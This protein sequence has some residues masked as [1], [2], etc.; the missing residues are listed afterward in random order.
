MSW[1]WSDRPA[2]A[3]VKHLIGGDK[4]AAVY[5]IGKYEVTVP[6]EER[7]VTYRVPSH[8]RGDP[9][10][11][12]PNMEIR[13]GEV[14]IPVSDFADEILSRVPA[15][16]LA[17]GLWENDEVRQAFLE[18]VPTRWDGSFSD[19]ERR[20]LLRDLKETVHSVALDKLANT[21]AKL[22]YD[23]SKRSFH[24]HEVNR[25]NDRLHEIEIELRGRLG[26]AAFSLPRVRHADNDGDFAI[27]G[28][29][30]NEARED[31]RR[32]VLARYPFDAPAL[33][34]TQGEEA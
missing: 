21:M 25:V 28:K 24:Y 8:Y 9:R 34:K 19:F 16:E 27:S 11:S 4:P 32:E 14:R 33:L 5:S 29:Y 15:P 10:D 17:Q 23:S 26:D 18:L 31:W 20:Q 2:A 12:L 6:G 30:W 22:E 7:E 1:N 3:K 13:D